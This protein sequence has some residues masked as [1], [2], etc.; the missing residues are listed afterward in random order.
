[1]INAIVY[2]FKLWRLLKRQ[3]QVSEEH[4]RQLQILHRP[5]QDRDSIE[6]ERSQAFHDHQEFEGALNELETRYIIHQIRAYRLPG[7]ESGE[8]E[9]TLWFRHLTRQ[10]LARLRSAIRAEQ[11]ERFERWSRWVPLVTGL[12]GALTGL[13]GVVIGLLA[14]LAR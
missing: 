4:D 13:I 1:M 14:T 9:E 6:G 10:A 12:T 7:A 8:W 11:K 5:P 2:R 3:Q